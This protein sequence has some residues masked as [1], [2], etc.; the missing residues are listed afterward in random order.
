VN[1]HG[2]RRHR[3][4]RTS[5]AK[6]RILLLTNSL[7][8]GGAETQFVRLALHLHG[9]GHPVMVA[10]ILPE[11]RG[12]VELRAAGIPHEVLPLRAPVRG[13][14]LLI[15]GI[16]VLAGAVRLFRRWRPD[17]VVSFLFYAN[18]LGRL[19]GALAGVPIVVSSVRTERFGGRI[20]DTA[21]RFTDRMARLTV[22]NCHNTARRLAADGIVPE[23]RL[24]VIPNGVPLEAYSDDHLNRGPTRQALGVSD[25]D[26]LWLAV[27]HLEPIK[28]YPTL[29]RAMT[30]LRD[31]GLPAKLRIAAEGSQR[32]DLQ[33]LIGDLQ[34]TETV[35]LL[36]FRS[37]VPELL[38]AAD[39][40]VLS[41]LVEGL[42]N[43]VIEA[44]AAGVPVVATNRGGTTEL[45]EPGI[46]GLLVPPRD[47]QALAK[48]MTELMQ[49]PADRRSEM[50]AAGSL[51][52]A[53]RF[54]LNQVMGRWEQ[55]I[56]DLV[57]G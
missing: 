8:V 46:T 55:L 32:A 31:S 45:V 17:V 27:G 9:A 11:G 23:N 33:A 44:F 2:F 28:D 43:V 29:L 15:R 57:G 5:A 54:S 56:A 22:T 39:A 41:S 18:L 14:T 24:Q 13:I 10:T 4:P 53:K 19:A 26:F 7:A 50:G 3:R 20:S 42:P 36:G 40:L 52:V 38:T 25:D 49:L 48:A 34:L 16:T 35:N 21:L 47:P 37:D 6:P 51:L 1:V 30:A 12:H